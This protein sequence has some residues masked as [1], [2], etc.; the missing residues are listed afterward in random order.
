M[1]AKTSSYGG[2]AFSVREVEYLESLPAV[3]RVRSGRIVYSDDFKRECIRR[4][5]AGESPVEIFREAGLDSSLIGYKRIERCIARWRDRFAPDDEDNA[6]QRSG[7]TP[8]PG[9]GVG[10]SPDVASNVTARTAAANSFVVEASQR[11]SPGAVV[12]RGADARESVRGYYI[13]DTGAY[14]GVGESETGR[15]TEPGGESPLA[16]STV[17]M[18][19]DRARFNRDA[20]D[21][22]IEYQARRIQELERELAALKGVSRGQ[23]DS[24]TADVS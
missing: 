24:R 18:T 3:E 7:A 11:W 19:D 8:A 4:Y 10:V 6:G 16:T 1:S 5:N 23:C 15:G 13:D 12:R 14:S 20:R 22:I 9:S 17:R 21:I 2:G